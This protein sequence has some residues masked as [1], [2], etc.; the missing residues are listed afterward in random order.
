MFESD[1]YIAFGEAGATYHCSAYIGKAI[2]RKANVL[3]PLLQEISARI[4]TSPAGSSKFPGVSPDKVSGT[5][6][7]KVQ[8]PERYAPR[9]TIMIPHAQPN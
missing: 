7:S 1:C 8:S 4:E 5:A 9:H 6:H 3:G 2:P